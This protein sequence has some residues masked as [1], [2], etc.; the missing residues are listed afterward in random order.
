[1]EDSGQGYGQGK[2]LNIFPYDTGPPVYEA[3]PSC[4][5]MHLQLYLS[6]VQPPPTAKW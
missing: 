3:C 1:M 2:D 4:L 6:S 5:L